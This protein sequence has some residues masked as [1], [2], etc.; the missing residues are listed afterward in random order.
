MDGVHKN[1]IKNRI[2]GSMVILFIAMVQPITGGKA[3][4][5]PPITIF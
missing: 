4:A 2:I 1:I 5:A 3:P